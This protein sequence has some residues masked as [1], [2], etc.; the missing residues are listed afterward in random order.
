[1]KD[2]LDQTGAGNSP[3]V[4]EALAHWQRGTF[5]LSPEQARERMAT[6]KDPVARRL[7][8]MLA[9]RS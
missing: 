7:L 6:E 5:K 4:L 9:S 8:A 3:G 1:V 2:Y